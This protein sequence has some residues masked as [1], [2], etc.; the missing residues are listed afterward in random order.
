MFTP[1]ARQLWHGEKPSST[2]ELAEFT[3]FR[4]SNAVTEA[5]AEGSF[6]PQ[7]VI[8]TPLRNALLTEPSKK[9]SFSGFFSSYGSEQKTPLSSVRCF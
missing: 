4:S 6:S 7:K 3:L 9:V 8:D 2:Q 1:H 5:S